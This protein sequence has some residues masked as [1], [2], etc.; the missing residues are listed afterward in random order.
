MPCPYF[1]PLWPAR[2]PAHADARLPLIQE[3]EGA[4]H[5]TEPTSTPP[6]ELRFRCC[7]HGYSRGQCGRFPHADVISA[8]RYHVVRRTAESLELLCIEEIEH[9]PGRQL[10]FVYDVRA[11]S[12]IPPAA[13]QPLQ[14]QALAFCRSY[15]E[16]FCATEIAT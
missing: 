6:S 9:R 5:A 15:L 2:S 10:R 11:A 4:C 1:E 7:N 16:R 14:A 8:L 13:N 3:Y 12:L